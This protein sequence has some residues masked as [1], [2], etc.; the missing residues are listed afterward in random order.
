MLHMFRTKS[1]WAHYPNIEKL[2]E[3]DFEYLKFNQMET[4][5]AIPIIEIKEK[6]ILNMVHEMRKWKKDFLTNAVDNAHS[7]MSR[8][9][10]RK[11]H[12]P[13]LAILSTKTESITTNILS[14]C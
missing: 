4:Y 13:V 10:L 12:Q 8:F 6:M 2:W 5:P 9:W 1:L 11:T 3:E 14:R 7:E